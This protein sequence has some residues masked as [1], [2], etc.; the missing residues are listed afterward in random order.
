MIRVRRGVPSDLTYVEALRRRESEAI[1]FLPLSLYEDT[2]ARSARRR[3]HML[4]LAEADGDRVGFLLLTTGRLGGALH[5]LQLA[6]QED[7]RRR[8]Y[9]AALLAE[10]ERTATALQRAGV[11]ARVAADLEA[12]AFWAAMGYELRGLLCGGQRR[13]RILESR[14]KRLA[15]GLWAGAG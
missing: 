1:G 13:G 15:C 14:Y 10:A 9:G 3:W 12:T 8:E 4:W 11:S 5:V 2:L 6:I 7:A